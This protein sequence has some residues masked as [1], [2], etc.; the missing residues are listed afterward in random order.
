MTKP[1]H[2]TLKVY[3]AEGRFVVARPAEAIDLQ[4]FANLGFVQKM[5]PAIKHKAITAAR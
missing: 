1:R 3:V 4:A 5:D 2:E